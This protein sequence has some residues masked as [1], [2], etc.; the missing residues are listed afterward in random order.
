MQFDHALGLVT[1]ADPSIPINKQAMVEDLLF[2]YLSR[3][4]HA[5]EVDACV[6]M[7]SIIRLLN[8]S[9]CEQEG[10][11]GAYATAGLLITQPVRDFVLGEILSLGENLSLAHLRAPALAELKSALLGDSAA[12]RTLLVPDALAEDMFSEYVPPFLR[13]AL[14][15]QQ[16]SAQNSAWYTELEVTTSS[17]MHTP[18]ADSLFAYFHKLD[19]S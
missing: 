10:G 11:G 3:L 6:L 2:M 15:G 13:T 16:Q 5:T 19:A 8:A 12:A 17:A 1:L 7:H 4:R 9:A 18:L 14:W